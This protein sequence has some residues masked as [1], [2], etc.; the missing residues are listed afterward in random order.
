MTTTAPAVA[1]A[2][3][4]RAAGGH[5]TLAAYHIGLTWATYAAFSWIVSWGLRH[6]FHFG[7]GWLGLSVLA[8][9]GVAL[10]K[11]VVRNV[12]REHGKAMALGQIDAQKQAM[13]EQITQ[14]MQHEGGADI[15]ASM[16]GDLAPKTAAAAEAHDFFGQY[17]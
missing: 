7:V 5:L 10:A 1:N 17:V 8:L 11:M 3:K 13:A 14:L 9:G 2:A 15:L 12:S 16:M 6:G 4:L